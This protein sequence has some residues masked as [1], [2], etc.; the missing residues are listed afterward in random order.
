MSV[1]RL[2]RD[3]ENPELP[4]EMRLPSLAR[5]FPCLKG[6]PG[7]NP[8]NTGTLHQWLLTR[9]EDSAARHAGLLILNLGGKGPWATFDAI[10]AVSVFDEENRTVFANWARSWRPPSA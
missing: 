3:Y 5:R 8:F 4:L 2:L 1:V 6:A 10:R 9:P 7:L